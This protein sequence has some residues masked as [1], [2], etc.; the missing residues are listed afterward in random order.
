[1]LIKGLSWLLFLFLFFNG[2]CD[3]TMNVN[4]Y[5][6]YITSKNEYQARLA[7]KEGNTES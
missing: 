4:K 6:V 3:G 2:W 1:M 5:M 7:L